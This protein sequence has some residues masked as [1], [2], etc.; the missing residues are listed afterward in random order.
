MPVSAKPRKRHNRRKTAVQDLR[1]PPHIHQALQT[2]FPIYGLLA[3]L[4]S[5]EISA[6]DGQP[7]MGIWG[8]DYCEVDTP[9]DGWISCWERIVSGERVPID[10]SPLRTLRDR[11]REDEMLDDEL[12]SA[13][14]RVTDQ[15]YQVYL[16]TP[17]A[18]MISYSKTE[19]IAITLDELGLLA[20]ADK[21]I[22]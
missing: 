6:V 13:A 21:E 11:L 10:L 9:L 14:K 2:F 15:C 16:S 22:S 20:P 7:I 12:I 19:E 1:R 3:N 18:R 8:G 4:E 17:R 5:G